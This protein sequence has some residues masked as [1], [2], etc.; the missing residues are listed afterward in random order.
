MS[1]IRKEILSHQAY[2]V[3][4]NFAETN[5]LINNL[6]FEKDTLKNE[7]AGNVET[8]ELISEIFIESVKKLIERL[9]NNK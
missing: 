4:T 5:A 6:K 2:R 3:L 9:K 7:F 8:K 1:Q